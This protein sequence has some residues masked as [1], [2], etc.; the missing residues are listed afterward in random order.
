[1]FFFDDKSVTNF[2]KLHIVAL[3][4]RYR[5]SFCWRA[6]LSILSQ[7]RVTDNT[8]ILSFQIET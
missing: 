8:L 1:M 4:F 2:L 3:S 6:N 5:I 7:N